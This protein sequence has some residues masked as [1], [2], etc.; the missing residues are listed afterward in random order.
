MRDELLVA[1]TV[2]AIADPSAADDLDPYVFQITAAHFQNGAVP[3]I[4]AAGFAGAET[5]TLWK[6]TDG[7]WVKVYSGGSAVQLTAT[8]P[9]ETIFSEGVYGVTK[10]NDSGI[11]VTVQMP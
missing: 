1:D 11:T 4:A 7:T 8:N 6:L 3:H 9:Q 2:T 10:S 5:V